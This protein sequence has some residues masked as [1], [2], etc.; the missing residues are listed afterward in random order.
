MRNP[1]P[2]WKEIGYTWLHYVCMYITDDVARARTA[3][4]LAD[5]RE[6]F[7]RPI[8]RST[9][10]GRRLRRLP[11]SVG[12]PSIVGRERDAREPDRRARR[13]KTRSI[14]RA[15]GRRS[16]DE[17][18]ASR[19]AKKT[20]SIVV[21]SSSSATSDSGVGREASVR[22]VP[23]NRIESNRTNESSC[24]ARSRL[25]RRVSRARPRRHR[26]RRSR[27]SSRCRDDAR[28]R[29]EEARTGRPS[30]GT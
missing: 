29:R 14:V 28:R 8:D 25:A 21:A 3:P 2:R 1:K 30:N 9:D 15:R 4:T 17:S 11:L 26:A 12:R 16:S 27:T 13:E 22:G 10:R 20:R 23:S 5:A 7:V 18:R 24:R 19:D 6:R